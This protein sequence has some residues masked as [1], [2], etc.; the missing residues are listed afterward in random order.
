MPLQGESKEISGGAYR[1]ALAARGVMK[2][3]STSIRR[4]KNCARRPSMADTAE[5]ML[6]LCSC[7]TWAEDPDCVEALSSTYPTMLFWCEA[8]L[9]NAS[10]HSAGSHIKSFNLSF[11]LIF[12]KR[13]YYCSSNS[14][15]LFLVIPRVQR[16]VM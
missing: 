13:K 11:V 7:L 6:V 12:H 8:D 15:W 16:S 14:P 3:V 10:S 1:M 2:G 4:L 9:S 5:R